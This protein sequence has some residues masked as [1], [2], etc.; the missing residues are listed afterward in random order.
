ML[1]RDRRE[2]VEMSVLDR[3]LWADT[4]AGFGAGAEAASLPS[5]VDVAVVGAGFTGLAAALALAKRGR[6][7]AVLE[8]HHVGWGA[9]S[10]NAGMVLTGVK[11]PLSALLAR[12][13]ETARRIDATSAAAIDLVARL[14][15]DEGFDCDFRRCGHLEVACSPAQFDVVKRATEIQCE[16]YG[17]EIRIVEKDALAEEIGSEAFAGGAVDPRSASVN[18]AKLVAGLATACRRAGAS[19]CENAGVERIER[20]SPGRRHSLVTARGEIAAGEVVLACGAY[21]DAGAGGLRSRLVPIGSFVIATEPL[22]AELR[23]RLIP[24]DRM[25]FDSRHYLNYFRWTP[26]GRM[27]FGGRAAFAP[28]SPATLERS[29]AILRREMVCAFPELDGARIDYRWGGSLDFTYDLLPHAGMLDGAH[30]AVGY[31][32]H[33]VA[34]A[35]YLG[36]RLGERIAGVEVDD[37]F[38]DIPIPHAPLRASFL[39]PVLLPLVGAWYKLMDWAS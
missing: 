9:S 13:E 12:G 29:A 22:D 28:P 10:R 30:F 14:A 38:F 35:T 4:V 24:R 6:K 15:D 18:P 11:A 31:A 7:V 33:G 19:I 5:Q 20:R 26:D 36:T 21:A 27:L 39:T 23:R 3:S 34:M 37:P 25:V 32:G 2:P 8:R 17:A 16:L 1:S